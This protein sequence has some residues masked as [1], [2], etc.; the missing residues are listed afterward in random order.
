MSNIKTQSALTG[1]GEQFTLFAPTDQAFYDIGSLV[2]NLKADNLTD[3]LKYHA[4]GEVA[5]F[6][7]QL[8]DGMKIPTLQG[9][10]LTV[11]IRNIDN[12]ELVFIN[13]ARIV[14]PNLITNQGV[15]H[16]IDKSVSLQH[17]NNRI[18]QTH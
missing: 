6:A 1:N 14:A 7:N 8:K 3:I 11:S 4:A 16:G 2:P 9:N 15:V 17:K 12:E 10:D 13:G 18:V 5:V